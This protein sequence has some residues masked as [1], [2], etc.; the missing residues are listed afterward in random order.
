MAAIGLR[1]SWATRSV[2]RPTVAI[3]SATSSSCWVAC[4]RLSVPVTSELSRSTSLRARRSRSATIPTVTA[5]IPNSAARIDT[6]VQPA[7]GGASADAAANS[8]PAMSA[9]ARATHGPK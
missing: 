4:S 5:G 6:A 9:V 7:K 3:R 8:A 1:T 2:K